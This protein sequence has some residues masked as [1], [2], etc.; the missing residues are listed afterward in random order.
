MQGLKHLFGY[1]VAATD[2]DIGKVEDFFVAEGAWS[3]RHLVVRTGGILSGERAV[4]PVECVGGPDAER[5]TLNVLFSKDR[6]EE[7][8]AASAVRPVSATMEERASHSFGPAESRRD[9][10]FVRVNCPSAE[11]GSDGVVETLR[12]VRE[13]TGYHLETLDGP[14]G[15]CTDLLADVNDWSVPYLVI[16]TKEWQ[17]KGHILVPTPWVRHISWDEMQI[18]VEARRQKI[19]KCQRFDPASHDVSRARMTALHKSA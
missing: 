13:I 2:T 12:S 6:L 9:R 18:D 4:V 17:P 5:R 11:D 19:Q 14:C 10:G 3:V 16:N 15:I 7:F 8:A 1:R